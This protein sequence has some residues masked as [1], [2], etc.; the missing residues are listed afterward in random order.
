[1]ACSICLGW[2]SF[3]MSTK[4]AKAASKSWPCVPVV[5]EEGTLGFI[6][7]QSRSVHVDRALVFSMRSN[8]LGPNISILVPDQSD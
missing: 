4:L 7:L 5:P 6:V 2:A 8:P 3:S 1:M